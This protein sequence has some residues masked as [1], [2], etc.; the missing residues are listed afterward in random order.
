MCRYVVLVSDSKEGLQNQ[1]NG[2]LTFCEK[3]HDSQRAKN[4]S[5]H[6]WL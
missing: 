1:L 2:P 4:E 6:I 5:D 3:P